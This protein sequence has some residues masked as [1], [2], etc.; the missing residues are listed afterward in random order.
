MPLRWKVSGITR[1]VDALAA[2]GAGA[3]AIG[4]VFLQDDPRSVRVEAAAEI[5]GALPRSTWR[6]GAF[7]DVE[8]GVVAAAIDRVGLDFVELAGCQAPERCRSL[9]RHAFKVLNVRGDTEASLLEERAE[10]HPECT[11]LVRVDGE[12]PRPESLRW[13]AVAGLA[14][15]HRL[16][17]GGG[18][19]D[20]ESLREIVS[21]VRPWAVE[22]EAGVE[23]S[24]GVKD[25]ELLASFGRVV[26]TF[27]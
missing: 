26:R 1:M 17:L 4:F 8:A 23:A 18:C 20:C 2:V 19:I 12:L 21:A 10:A 6:F 3:D 25:R 13:R 5:S 15:R 11:L 22:V 9:G 7:G 27:G 14:R 24:P 16:M